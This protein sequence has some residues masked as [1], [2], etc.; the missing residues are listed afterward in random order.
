[1]I[2]ANDTIPPPKLGQQTETQHGVGRGLFGGSY[3]SGG[4]G[5]APGIS[6][7]A[8]LL[9]GVWPGWS[10]LLCGTYG[11]YRAMARH[12]TIAKSTSDALSPVLGSAWM[13]DADEDAPQAAK[14]WVT[15]N[16]VRHW[17]RVIAHAA[18]SVILGNSPF[19][20]V[21]ASEGGNFVIRDFVPL[22]PDATS[23]MRDD[24][25]RGPFAGIQNGQAKLARAECLYVLN[26]SDAISDEPGD[27]YGRSRYENFRDTAWTGW[28]DTARKLAELEDRVS[29]V[30]PIIIV[31]TGMARTGRALPPTP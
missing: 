10:S 13:V 25:G 20:V 18:R 3:F 29:G 4:V 23:V 14:D 16:I 17:Q 15:D 21:W 31:P 27:D 2:A 30:I 8:G 6:E 11:T 7:T 9:G 28:L 5:F 1:M 26:R 24:G 12:P 22:L 19:E